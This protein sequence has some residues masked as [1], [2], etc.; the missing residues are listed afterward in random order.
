[1]KTSSHQPNPMAGFQLTFFTQHDHRHHGKSLAQW[2]L[3]EARAM[4]IV[5]SEV[6][7][8]LVT[9]SGAARSP[10]FSRLRIV[11]LLSLVSFLTSG[12]RPIRIVWP[13]L[14]HAETR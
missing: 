14:E 8:T 4:G 1:M 6:V 11:L 5:P 10:L 2:L 13:P 7:K 3:D 12:S 9:R